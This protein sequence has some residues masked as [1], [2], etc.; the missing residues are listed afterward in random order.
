MKTY[1][2][3]VIGCGRMGGFI[4]NEVVGAPGHVPPY[5]HGGGF[6]ACDR[7]DLVACSDFRADLMAVFGEQYAVPKS[8]QYTDYQEMIARED[9]DIVSVA[10]HV[11]HHADIVIHAAEHGVKAIFCEKGMAPSLAT[12]N[13]MAAACERHGTAFNMGTQRRYHPGFWQMR[14]IIEQGELGPLQSL[15]MT[16]GG[17]LFDHGC[18]TMDLALYLNGDARAV[19]VQGNA[20]QSEPLR[21]GHVYSDDPGG[22]GVIL[23]EN[24]VTLY[25]LC[26]NRYEYQANC[27]HGM[28]GTFNDTLDWV[29]RKGSARSL[30]PV[31]FPAF[32]R[33]STTVNAI[34]DLVQALDTGGPPRGGV[35]SARHGVEIMVAILESH[36]QGGKRIALP[37]RES[38]LRMHRTD[39]DAWQKGAR[40]REPKLTV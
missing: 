8:R 16:Y 21:D 27:A 9:L 38:N 4:D 10:T 25:L 19:W 2:A 37:L 39:R 15:V 3:A 28:V 14:E 7:T 32:P 35:A 1:R 6:Y 33:Q 5:A 40:W 24:G 22:D 17:G 31:E 29:M 23:F 12:A 30:Q 11:E 13:A 36:L 18:H 26:T 34:M 20:P